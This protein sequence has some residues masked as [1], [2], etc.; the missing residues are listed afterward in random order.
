MTKVKTQL[1]T[2]PFSLQKLQNLAEDSVSKVKAKEYILK[3]F[4]PLSTNDDALLTVDTEDHTK[5]RWKII[6]RE[7][8]GFLNRFGKDLKKWYISEYP[9]V[10]YVVSELDKPRFFDKTKFNMGGVFLHK[11]KK[12]DSYD[13]ETKKGV[14]QILDFIYEVWACEDKEVYEYLLKWFANVAKGIKNSTYLYVRG[15]KGCGK[16]WLCE[17][18]YH[19]VFGPEITEPAKHDIFLS[20]NNSS[21]AGKALVYIDDMKTTRLNEYTAVDAEI[22]R[23]TTSSTMKIEEKYIA[24]YTVKNTNNYIFCADHDALKGVDGRRAFCPDVSTKRREDHKYFNSLTAVYTKNRKVGEAFYNYLRSIDT[25]EFNPQIKPETKAKNEYKAK[26]LDSV[27]A[28]LKDTYIIRNKD[29]C[30][31]V[32]ELYKE[33][34]YYCVENKSF[35]IGLHEFTR[36][37]REVDLDFKKTNGH[38]HYKLKHVDLLKIAQKYNWISEL[39]EYDETSAKNS[40][41]NEFA[42]LFINEEE[43]DGMDYVEAYDIH[44]KKLKEQEELIRTLNSQ[45]EELK[46]VKKTSKKVKKELKDKKVRKVKKEKFDYIEAS[47]NVD[48]IDISF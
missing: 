9:G 29:I 10:R 39:D 23:L 43:D 21:I 46:N 16:S 32:R 6:S 15:P 36:K 25:S 20:K 30:I 8:N 31:P 17:M 19:E 18:L 1:P 44:Q 2:E 13:D 14:Q 48:R 5:L 40:D 4:C 33:Y 47:K 42:E 11:K 41:Q 34:Q 45:L 27:Y 24:Q 7:K 38:N 35:D 28:F 3:Y 26:R 37:M 22:K 12:Y